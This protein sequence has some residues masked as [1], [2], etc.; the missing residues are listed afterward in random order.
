[1]PLV[2]LAL[3]FFFNPT[4]RTESFA[5]RSAPLSPGSTGPGMVEPGLR[6]RLG[7][8]PPYSAPSRLS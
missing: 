8:R 4:P 5:P 3:H 1:M 6:E 7:E 2:F